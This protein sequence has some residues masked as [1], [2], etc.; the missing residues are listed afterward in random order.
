MYIYTY[1]Y[2]YIYII[3]M[4]IYVCVCLY[5]YRQMYTEKSDACISYRLTDGYLLQRCVVRVVTNLALLVYPVLRLALR[6]CEQWL[7]NI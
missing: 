6:E 4:Y 5:V 2:T 7:L 3:Y 1:I